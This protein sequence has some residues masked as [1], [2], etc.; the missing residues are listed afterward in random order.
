MALFGAPI[1]HEDHA[2]ARLLRRAAPRARAARA[3]PTSCAASAGSSFSVRMGLNSGEVVVGR[4]GDDLRMDYTAQGHAVGLAARME[5]LAEPGGIYLTE[6]HGAARRRA[7]RPRRPRRAW[8]SRAR[9]RRCACLRAAGRRAAAHAPRRSRARGLSRFVGRDAR[10]G[11]LETRSARAQSGRGDGGRWSRR[12]RA[13]ERAGSATS[14]SSAAARRGAFDMSER[15]LSDAGK[16]FHVEIE[17]AGSLFGR[18]GRVR[19][20]P[21]TPG[22][23]ASTIAP[24][25]RPDLWL[26]SSRRRPISRRS[27]TRSR[28]ARR[29]PLFRPWRP[30]ASSRAGRTTV[31]MID[32]LHWI[33]AESDVARRL[34]GDS[35]RRRLSSSRTSVRSIMRL[36]TPRVIAPRVGAAAFEAAEPC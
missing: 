7:L 19:R 33:D 18:R 23:P 26:R 12:G 10:D 3:T 29:T 20:T 34:A 15:A 32:D 36:S 9:A 11:S 5:Q 30:D 1:A 6:Q 8:T 22:G 25:D 17:F 16:A 35:A 14:S 2:P 4:I 24:P 28:G 31:L 13:R 21:G 27:A